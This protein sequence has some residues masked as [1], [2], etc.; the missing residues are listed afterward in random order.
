[1]KQYNVSMTWGIY[2]DRL[3]KNKGSVLAVWPLSLIKWNRY[4]NLFKGSNKILNSRSHTK[5]PT[6]KGDTFSVKAIVNFP[7]EFALA[8]IALLRSVLDYQVSLRLFGSI[9]YLYNGK[10]NVLA[11]CV[12]NKTNVRCISSIF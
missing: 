9:P 4:P 6:A 1:M 10:W 7:I 3:F 2:H 8:P 11:Y 12:T 5:K